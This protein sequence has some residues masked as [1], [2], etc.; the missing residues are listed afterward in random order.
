MALNGN[1]ITGDNM[2]KII[3]IVII[4]SLSLLTGCSLGNTPT[5][6]VE[7]LLS[8]Y[9][10]LDN[11]ISINYISIAT[12]TN[13]NQDIIKRYEDV[14]RDQYRNLSYEIKE[15]IIDGESAIVTTQI[16]VMDYKTIINK[17]NRNDYE[18][19][20]YHDLVLN[21]LEDAT[22][23]ITYTIEFNLIKGEEDKWQVNNL[24]T[25]EEQKLLGIS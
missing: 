8:K 23:K 5:A 10:M 20:K 13:L 6:Q 16:E 14:I 3:L 4:F 18:L 21:D 22:E 25:E 15:E 9:Q 11:E 24:T 17:Y 7:E 2:K 12:D 1:I 19:E